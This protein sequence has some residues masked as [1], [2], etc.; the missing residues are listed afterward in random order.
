M[1]SAAH[2]TMV[3]FIR[4]HPQWFD[5]LLRAMGHGAL[6]DGA[7]A[8][9]PSARV[10]DPGTV[11]VDVA[12]P[13]TRGPGRWS[14]CNATTIPRR[15]DGGWR[16]PLHD[17]RGGMGDVFAVT[18]ARSVARWASTA[19]VV[20]GRHGTRLALIPRVVCLRA[21]TPRRC[22]R[23]GD[24]SWRCSPRGRYTRSAATPPRGSCDGRS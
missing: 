1:P 13:A 22:S 10:V 4:S 3:E 12:R 17:R 23:P 5:A 9:D 20:E 14:N 8:V 19:A 2:E 16:R 24:R 11:Q 7:R 18:H 15:G 21:R 6:P